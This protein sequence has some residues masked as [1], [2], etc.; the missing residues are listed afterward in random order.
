MDLIRASLALT[1]TQWLD[2]M[3][4]AHAALAQWQEDLRDA[5]EHRYPEAEIRTC[6][7]HIAEAEALLTSLREVRLP[8]GLLGDLYRDHVYKEL[9]D[10]QASLR[11]NS[12]EA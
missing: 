2:L 1:L 8:G 3:D 12:Q 11:R 6:R 10:V 7:T 5:E 4:N 9:A